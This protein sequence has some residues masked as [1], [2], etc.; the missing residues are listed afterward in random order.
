[1]SELDR[2][3]Y[4]WAKAQLVSNAQSVFCRLFNFCRSQET[5]LSFTSKYLRPEDGHTLDS[6]EEDIIKWCSAAL[7][8]GCADTMSAVNSCFCTAFIFDFFRLY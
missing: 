2:K 1:M 6:E 4:A 5:M 7:Y 8:V 3:P